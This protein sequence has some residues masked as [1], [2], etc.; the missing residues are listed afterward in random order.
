V[1]L[2]ME[3]GVERDRSCAVEALLDD[4]AAAVATG[5]RDDGQRLGARCV[6]VLDVGSEPLQQGN[7]L[8][9]GGRVAWADPDRTRPSRRRLRTRRL[10]ALAVLIRVPARS[11][12]AAIEPAG[13]PQFQYRLRRIH[14]LAIELAPQA[15]HHRH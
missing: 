5:W 1:L 8:G 7:C 12:L 13:N 10:D 14:R 11:R 6:A 9:A 3:E 2:E 15:L 4:F